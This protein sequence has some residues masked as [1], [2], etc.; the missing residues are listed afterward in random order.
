MFLA[1]LAFWLNLKKDLLDN[2]PFLYISKLRLEEQRGTSETGEE[3]LNCLRLCIAPIG[4]PYCVGLADS[5]QSA[6]IQSQS[7]V[8]SAPSATESTDYVGL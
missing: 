8:W 5:P 6:F 3:R 1:F 2:L 4:I 7:R